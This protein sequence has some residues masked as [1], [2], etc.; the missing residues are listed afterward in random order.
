MHTDVSEYINLYRAKT[1]K[2]LSQDT[3]KKEDTGISL[4]SLNRVCLMIVWI[5]KGYNHE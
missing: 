2:L 3:L 1:T 4:E 5:G